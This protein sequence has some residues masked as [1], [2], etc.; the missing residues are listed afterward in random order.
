VGKAVDWYLKMLPLAANLAGGQQPAHAVPDPDPKIEVPEDSMLVNQQ[1]YQVIYPRLRKAK[2]FEI[3]PTTYAALH[4]LADVY[5]TEELLHERWAPYPQPD[6]NQ[7]DQDTYNYGMSLKKGAGNVPFPDNLPFEQTY[8]GYAEPIRLTEAGEIARRINLDEL[9]QS[10]GASG[11]RLIG[12]LVCTETQRIW[13]FLAGEDRQGAAVGIITTPVYKKGLWV[14]PMS[15]D[16][17]IMSGLVGVLNDPKM[18]TEIHERPVSKKKRRRVQKGGRLKEVPKKYYVVEISASLS[19]T[20]SRKYL[21]LAVRQSST[22]TVQWSHR[23][24]SRAHERLLVQRGSYPLANE[25]AEDLATR[26]YKLYTGELDDWAKE[27]LKSRHLPGPGPGEWV[28][29]KIVKVKAS[30]K[31]PENMP[32]VPALHRLKKSPRAKAA[33]EAIEDVA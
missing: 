18:T 27:K 7:T 19:K 8:F 5:T 31:G 12:Q 29:L 26:D 22:V 23:W 33:M 6:W 17:W 24:D 4:H 30:V 21:P 13:E 9:A 28:A 3:R 11:V 10:M 16:A 14:Y 15:L 25:K 1:E 2:I 32:Y 20:K